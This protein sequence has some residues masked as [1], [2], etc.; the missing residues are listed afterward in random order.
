MRGTFGP[1]KSMQCRRRLH[2][3]WNGECRPI[4]AIGN[5]TKNILINGTSGALILDAECA[6]Y[7]DPAFDLAFVLNHLVLKSVHRPDAAIALRAAIMALLEA[8]AAADAPAQA[9]GVQHRAAAL[10]PALLLA[11]IDGKSPVEYLTDPDKKAVVHA[12]ARRFLLAP[13][14]HPIEIAMAVTGD[15]NA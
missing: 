7:G 10:L 2:Y 14:A 11:R 6:W 12:I 3:S 8:R 4:I 5:S 9:M 13:A 15:Q 1:K